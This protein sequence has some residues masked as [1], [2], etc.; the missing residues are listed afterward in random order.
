MHCTAAACLQFASVQKHVRVKL[1]TMHVPFICADESIKR[2]VGA[3]NKF[4]PDPAGDKW[5][6]IQGGNP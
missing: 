2:C 1:Q 4:A 5:T 3:A 6:Y